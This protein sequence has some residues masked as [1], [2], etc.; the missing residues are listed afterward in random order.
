M[1]RAGSIFDFHFRKDFLIRGKRI[2]WKP[3]P[4]VLV[5]LKAPAGSLSADFRDNARARSGAHR[6]L[7]SMGRVLE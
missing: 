3:L 1:S 4:A 6:I 5:P 7:L 2:P